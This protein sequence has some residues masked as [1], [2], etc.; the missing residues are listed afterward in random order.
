[1]K[2]EKMTMAQ[3]KAQTM[4]AR[5]GFQDTELTTPKHDEIMLWLDQW[6]DS[7]IDV[8]IPTFSEWAS[9]TTYASYGNNT[10]YS[11]DEF[12]LASP[13]PSIAAAKV[14]RKTWEYPITNKNYTI[15]FIDMA[16]LYSSPSPKLYYSLTDKK[17]DIGTDETVA[18]F[19]V[20]PSIPSLGEVIRQVRM[21]QTYANGKWFIVSPDTRFRDQLKAQRIGF[22]E[23][24]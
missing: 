16:V 22:V 21:Y 24:K 5:F 3:A 4:Q 10:R 23:V 20:K 13:L 11:L 14:D 17:F 19:E 12:N 18:Y 1:M 7:N 2:M 6:I 15:G 9:V 8:I